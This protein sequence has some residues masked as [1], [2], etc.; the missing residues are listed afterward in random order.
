MDLQS[1]DGLVVV[2]RP[3]LPKWNERN[4]RGELKCKFFL[5]N[6]Q[7]LRMREITLI[8]PS[9]EQVAKYLVL[10]FHCSPVIPFSPKKE[11]K[12]VTKMLAKMF[13][14]LLP[15]VLLTLLSSPCLNRLTTRLVPS[16]S[17][18]SQI[19]IPPYCNPMAIWFAD[20]H[21]TLLIHSSCCNGRRWMTFPASSFSREL[22]N[23]NSFLSWKVE[24]WKT[25]KTHRRWFVVSMKED[26]T[27]STEQ[28][29]RGRNRSKQMMISPGL[30]S[31]QLEENKRRRNWASS[32][33]TSSTSHFLLDE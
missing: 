26:V 27:S 10:S 22:Q 8:H 28:R 7:M 15:S 13:H 1:V 16:S 2:H 23:N 31:T 18:I 19:S 9:K 3:N 30:I 12:V 32:R 24:K 6:W 20:I 5:A 25:M 21:V 4:G 29:K 17:S 33:L 11:L 14:V